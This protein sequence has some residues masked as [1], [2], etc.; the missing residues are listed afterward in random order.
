M[1]KTKLRRYTVFILPIM[2]YWSD[3]GQLTRQIY[4]D[5]WSGPVVPTK[6]PGHSLA[7]LCQ[8]C[9]RP[10]HNQPATTHPSLRPVVSLSLG[11][12]HER[13]RTQMLAKPFSNLLQRTGGDHWGGRTQ[14]G[15]WTFMMTCLRC[16]LRYMRLEIWCKIGLS[17]D[18]CLCTVLH[19]CSGAC[20]DWEFST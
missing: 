3:A 11:I 14:L 19:L 12:L 9:R 15:W 6:D 7:L 18:W 4:R 5:W 17:G 8:K 1:N 20:I 10:L 13:M 2:L 16:I